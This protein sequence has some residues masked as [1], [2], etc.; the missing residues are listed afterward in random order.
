MG[1]AVDTERGL[2]VPVLRDADKKGL[3]AISQ[4]SKDLAERAHQ[5][6]LSPDEMRGGTFTLTNLGA[7]EVDAFTPLINL[8]ETAILGVGRILAR[9]AVHKGEIAIRQMM[10]LSLSFD[11]RVVDGGP[12]AR[13]LQEVKGLIEEP[14]LLLL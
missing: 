13:F 1:I 14:A 6:K 10:A 2:I 11:H 12:A 9:P 5:N 4:E 3:A 8:P 7:Y